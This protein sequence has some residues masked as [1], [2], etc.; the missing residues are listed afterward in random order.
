NISGCIVV[1]RR[2]KGSSRRA[3]RV[4]RRNNARK[5]DDARTSARGVVIATAVTRASFLL[6]TRTESRD[7]AAAGECRSLRGPTFPL[8]RSARA[9]SVRRDCYALAV[10]RR[11]LPP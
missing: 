8:L 7:S 10:F 2:K 11:A 9:E 4:S 5:I 6:A 1:R 3:T